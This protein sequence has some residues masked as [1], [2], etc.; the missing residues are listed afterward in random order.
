[1]RQWVAKDSRIKVLYLEKNSGISAASNAAASLASGDYLGF[2]DN[3]DELAVECLS[4]MVAVINEKNAELYYTDEDLIGEDGRQFSVF[5]KPD[6]NPEL[7]LCHNYITHFVLADAELFKNVGGFDAAKDGAQDHDLLLKMSEQAKGIIHIP[8]VLYHWRASESSTSINHEQKSYANEAG[9][10]SVED[11]LQRR[12]IVGRVNATDWKFFY[13]VRKKIEVFPVISLV[14][15]HRRDMNFRSWLVQLVQSCS[16]PAVEFFIIQDSTFTDEKSDKYDLDGMHIH[17]LSTEQSKTASYNEAVKQCTG[18]YVVFL[19]AGI[20]IQSSTWLEGLI[21]QCIAD[22]VGMAGGMMVP[23]KGEYSI[24][25]VPDLNNDSDSYYSTF[26]Q[27]CSRHMNGL[28]CTQNVCS[29]SWHFMMVDRSRF[30]ELGGFD[31]HLFPDLFADIDLCFRMREAGYTLVYS[32][33][34]V[35]KWTVSEEQM[36]SLSEEANVHAKKQFQQKWNHF[37]TAGD[38]FYNSGVVKQAGID[39]S[40]FRK[41]YTGEC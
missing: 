1:M 28:Q 6:F 13:S 10:V 32:P 20:E 5:H 33:L 39:L 19:D 38:P 22:N 41:W 2:L 21:E 34:A 37:L 23:L 8:E 25:T 15:V 27:D 16:Y 12:D 11:A 14:I 26:V 9:R 3:D 4:K 40:A 17:Q 36:T 29:L 24:T 30:L 35:G 7:L 31:E 18:E